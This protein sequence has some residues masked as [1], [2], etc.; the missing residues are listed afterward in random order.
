M[1]IVDALPVTLGWFSL[2]PDGAHVRAFYVAPEFTRRGVGQAM[3]A[4]AAA[5]ARSLGNQHLTIHASLNAEAFY[6]AQGFTG[7]ERAT[8]PLAASRRLRRLPCGSP[9]PTVVNRQQAGLSRRRYRH[10]SPSP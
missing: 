9:Y 3:M 7:D 10:A 1:L 4:V 5:A 8:V 6:R 2:T